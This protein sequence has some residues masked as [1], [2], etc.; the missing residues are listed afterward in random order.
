M[1]KGRH[2]ATTEKAKQHID[3]GAANN[4]TG[5]LVEGWNTGWEH[6]IGFDER[7]RVFDFLTPYPDYDLREATSYAKSKGVEIIM[8]HE[9]SAAPRTYEK[10]LDTAFALMQSLD[11]HSVKTGYVGPII[12]KGEYHHGQWMVNHYRRVLTTAAKYDIAINAHEPI[13]ATGIRRTYPNAIS[14]EGLRGQEF[15]AW[16]VEG[17][18][19]PAHSPIAT[20]LPVC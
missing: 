3:F 13:K 15:N 8:H 4:I 11:I 14:R 18:N 17:G 9:T 12:P 7:K 19:P 20:F 2:G 1:A 5:V 16:S 6:W 10:Q